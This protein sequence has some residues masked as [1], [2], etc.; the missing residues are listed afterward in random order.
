LI[1]ASAR[2]QRLPQKTLK[3]AR[4][5][6]QDLPER[7]GVAN[8]DFLRVCGKDCEGTYLPA[9][10]CWSQRNW[11][12]DHPVK[13]SAQATSTSTK[14]A[15]QGQCFR[16]SART[17]GH[18]GAAAGAVPIALKRAQPGHEG[19]SARRC[20]THSR[21]EERRRCARHLQ[22]VGQRYTWDWT[23]ARR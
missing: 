2:R 21:R 10:Q 4:L 9:G 18:G 8:N 16:R 5:R 20:A 22:H 19:I 13:K 12:N 1:G 7:T 23:S 15:G 14:G 11:P 3:E 17:R 6:G